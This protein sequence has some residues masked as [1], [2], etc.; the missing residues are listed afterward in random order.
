M[1]GLI[2]STKTGDL[3]TEGKAATITDNSGMV[4]ETVLLAQRGELKE[5]PLI[6]AEVRMHLGGSYDRFWPQETKKMIRACGVEVGTVAYD[7]DSGVIT[8]R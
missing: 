8:V 7:A 6:G 4:I 5:V 2:T 1:K 3:L